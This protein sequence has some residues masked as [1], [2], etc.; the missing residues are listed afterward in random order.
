MAKKACLTTS[1]ISQRLQDAGVQPTS[2]RISICQYVLCEADHPTAEQVFAWAEQ[3][4]P[5][6]SLATVYNT[7]GTLVQ[8]KLLREFR[9]PHTDKVI[10]DNNLEDHHHFLDETTS[11]LYDLHLEDIKVSVDLS[12]KFKMSSMEVLIKGTK[13]K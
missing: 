3:A 2:Q 11:R 8:A 7:L 9:F 5:K 12:K 6:I 1:E 10:Y 4:L 13:Q